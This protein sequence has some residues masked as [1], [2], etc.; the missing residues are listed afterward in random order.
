MEKKDIQLLLET[1]FYDV[2]YGLRNARTVIYYSIALQYYVKCEIT[3]RNRLVSLS[4]AVEWA[5]LLLV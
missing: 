5:A 1:F 3:S 4:A 2:V